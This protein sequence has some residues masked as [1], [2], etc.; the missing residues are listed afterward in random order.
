MHERGVCGCPIIF[1][2]LIKPR[3]IVPR[4]S[5]NPEHPF[6]P[7]STVV[8]NIGEKGRNN[9]NGKA[10]VDGPKQAFP[11]RNGRRKGKK[12]PT[13][14]YG[15]HQTRETDGGHSSSDQLG[16]KQPGTPRQP[17]VSEKPYESQHVAKST[18]Q[19]IPAAIPARI[20]SLYGAEWI[21]EHRQLHNVGSCKCAADFSYYQ[22]PEVY[23]I[24]ESSF[25]EIYSGQEQGVSDQSFDEAG[26]WGQS[27]GFLSDPTQASSYESWF[28][29]TQAYHPYH[30]YEPCFPN[31]QPN[32]IH[33]GA[34]AGAWSTAQQVCPSFLFSTVPRN[35]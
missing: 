31:G 28:Q 1:P 8:N 14:P 3:V 16:R 22:T 20:H 19:N 11:K 5:A 25:L 12:E 26:A 27:S 7:S 29:D 13:V 30:S 17:E 35:T 24:N 4:N 33:Q 18:G 34:Q 2:D 32:H 21:E 9:N 6:N 15:T 10:K 23:G